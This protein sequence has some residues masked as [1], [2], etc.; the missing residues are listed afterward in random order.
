[1]QKQ[2]DTQ[3]AAE[4]RQAFLRHLPKRL[5]TLRKRGLRLCTQG[6]DINALS[7]LFRE[8]QTLAGAC[9]RYGLLDIGEHLF[10]LEGFLAPFVEQIS[11]PNANQTETFAGLLGKLEPL[12]AQHERQYG[13]PAES[14]AAAALTVATE[15]TGGFSAAGDAATGILEALWHA[16]CG[17]AK[18]ATPSI[19]TSASAKP[20]PVASPA[21]PA[22]APAIARPAAAAPM[23]AAAPVPAAVPVVATTTPP[24]RHAETRKVYH[25]SDGNPLACEVD[26]KIEASGYELTLLDSVA[27]LKEMLAAFA[28]HLVVRR[29]AVPGRAGNDRRNDQGCAQPAQ[30]RLALL[31]FS[32]SGELSVRLRA[33]R[34]GADAFIELPAQSGDVMTRIGENARRRIGRSVPRADRRGRPRASDLRRIDPAQGRHEH[35]RGDRSAGRARPARRVPAGT[36]PDG[37]VHA[38]TATAWN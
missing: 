26:Q 29:C 27:E 10:S 3:Q 4:L 21:A 34:A 32:T 22:A 11:I 30:H 17:N 20:V 14:Q 7:L 23:P 18:P 6:W 8:L 1:V 36:H 38:G 16:A 24:P 35:L 28:P 12:I 13:E 31:T 37:S 2:D 33:M 15:Q 19:S 9:G 5:D 25:L